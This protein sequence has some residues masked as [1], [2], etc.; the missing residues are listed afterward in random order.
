MYASTN[1]AI[2]VTALTFIFL[3]G[4][5]V[6]ALFVGASTLPVVTAVLVKLTC[7]SG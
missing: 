7:P 5:Y 4:Q 6:A 2:E 1:P 3:S